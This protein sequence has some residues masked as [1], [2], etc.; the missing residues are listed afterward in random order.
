VCLAV[1]AKILSISGPRAEVDVMGNR[2]SADLSVLPDVRVG[3][4]VIVHAGLALQ[5]YDEDEALRT[6]E[7]F[8][9]LAAVS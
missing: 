9:E 3:D 6:I 5:K 8:R 1:P 2:M 7:L 4:Y